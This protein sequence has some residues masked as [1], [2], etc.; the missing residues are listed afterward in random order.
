MEN[1]ASGRVP[2]KASASPA[3]DDVLPCHPRKSRL[4]IPSVDS[5]AVGLFAV[6]T[7]CRATQQNAKTWPNLAPTPASAFASLEARCPSIARTDA[8][9]RDAADAFVRGGR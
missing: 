9:D 8:N 6:P 2:A 7:V 1:S 5:R 3:A 4:P